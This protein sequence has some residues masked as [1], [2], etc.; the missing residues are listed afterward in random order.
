MIIPDK[1]KKTVRVAV[2]IEGGKVV[3][4]N[5]TPLPKIRDGATG[6]LIFPAADILDETERR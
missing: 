5:R 3:K 2:R 4:S 1:Q 6:D